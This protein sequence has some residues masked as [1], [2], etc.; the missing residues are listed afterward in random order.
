M[1]IAVISDSHDNAKNLSRAV[2]ISNENN[3]AYIFHLGDIISP[4]TAK[5]MGDF[6]G[7]IKAVFGNCDGEKIGLLEAFDN[8]GY[9]IKK[10]PFEIKLKNKKIVLMHEP[11]LIDEM[12]ESG[13]VSYIFY[14]HLHKIDYRKKKKT[15][16]LNPGEICG[17]LR[18]PT[19]YIIDLFS[20][21]FEKIEL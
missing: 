7:T 3:C 11:F 13:K 4:Y 12:I 5:K 20:E 14:G 21:K 1:K 19:F 15:Y 8:M 17:L 9:E 2:A 18:K 16:I 10:P 6:N